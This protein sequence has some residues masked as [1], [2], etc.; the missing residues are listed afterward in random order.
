MKLKNQK[1]FTLIELMVVIVIIGILA[2]VAIPKMF[3]MSA[4]AKASEVGPV[5]AGWERA[6][7]AFIIETNQSAPFTN[8]GFDDPSTDSKNFTYTTNTSVSSSANA[9]LTATSDAAFD[10]CASGSTWTSTMLLAS[11]GSATRN[12]T[13]ASST[14]AN[15]EAL[16]PNF[17]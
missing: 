5:T 12:I 6:A 16:T 4:K 13:G 3:G 14:T 9:V 1:G 17:K 10:K 15:C 8:I 7:G 11:G 2:A